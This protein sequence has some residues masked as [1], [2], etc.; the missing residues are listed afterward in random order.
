[1]AAIQR[2][3]QLPM[4]MHN[5]QWSTISD[6]IKHLPQFPWYLSKEAAVMQDPAAFFSWFFGQQQ[7]WGLAMYEQDWMDKEYDDVTALQ[8][9]ITLGDMWLQGM[10]SGASQHGLTVQY[11]MPYPNQI[12]SGFCSLFCCICSPPHFFTL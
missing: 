8:S 9:N 7:G 1:M 2:K 3:I 6:Y 11:C 12:L 4:I 10:A 5:R